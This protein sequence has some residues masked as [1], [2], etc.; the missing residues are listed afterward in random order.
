M[1]TR[2]MHYSTDS[3]MW[4]GKSRPIR[5]RTA[6]RCSSSSSAGHCYG[7]VVLILLATLITSPLFPATTHAFAPNAS[8]SRA[9]LPRHISSR[10]HPSFSLNAVI[11]R[12]STSSAEASVDLSSRNGK[13]Q[14]QQQHVPRIP[15]LI[16]RL[17]RDPPPRVFDEISGMC[18][19][20]FFNAAPHQK[21][22]WKEWQLAYLRNL[23]RL[24][25]KAR[26][27][28]DHLV[29]MM[30]VARRVVPATAANVRQSPLLL[31]LTPVH[32]LP[33][34]GV[35]SDSSSNSSNN[36]DY[37][38][39]ELLGFVEV[40]QRPYGLGDCSTTGV[41]LRMQTS[42]PKRPVLTNLSVRAEARGAGV[43]SELM[44]VAEEAVQR[45][46]RMDEMILE[47]EDDNVRARQFYQHRGYQV[48][49]E[50]PAS[51]RYDTTGL[52]LKQIRCKSIVMRKELRSDGDD[53]SLNIMN[54]LD[55]GA[56]ALESTVNLLQRL[57]DG[58]FHGSNSQ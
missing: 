35:E 48:L 22:V 32:N 44:Q 6:A 31:D 2:K 49:F 10:I 16:E 45:Q 11:A 47:V 54:P 9:A 7:C 13:E 26:R 33:I 39:G 55:A 27:Q 37:V 58:I 18:I 53:L 14:H 3:S 29:N 15:F 50:D 1:V 34:L 43:G 30:F 42:N 19:D 41:Q 28:R 57:R 5:R 17:P 8:K 25:L 20:A 23:Q 40:T 36:R 52:F 12:T 38:R 21:H 46:W 56:L 51:R 4:L 24:D